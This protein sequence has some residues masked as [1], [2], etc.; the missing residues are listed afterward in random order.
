M[1]W[2]QVKHDLPNWNQVN[3]DHADK[4]QVYLDSHTQTKRFAARMK[5]SQFQPPPLTQDPGQSN[6]TLK[7]K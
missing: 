4:K 1:K 3:I 7:A 2:N 6:I 5:T